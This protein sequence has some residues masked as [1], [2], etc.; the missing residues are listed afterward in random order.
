[1]LLAYVFSD[2]ITVLDLT[3]MKVNKTIKPVPM[4]QL[5]RLELCGLDELDVDTAEALLKAASNLQ[6]LTLDS[7]AE[8]GNIR[9]VNALKNLSK[10]HSLSLSAASWVTDG[11]LANMIPSLDKLESLNV[12]HTPVSD[13]GIRII[14]HRCPNLT[15]LNL[16]HSEVTNPLVDQLIK[17]IEDRKS[18]HE[19]LKEKSPMLV[20]TPFE[21]V[22]DSTL[23][24]EENL[25]KL[26]KSMDVCI[27]D[28]DE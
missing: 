18:K 9:V 26:Q 20:L 15:Y 10:L 17:Y 1:M 7:S 27:E 19:K 6:I 5:E 14:L 16:K 4:P 22:I 11:I 21:L 8:L 28:D 3:G 24:D 12:S 13:A 25:A 2:I 23:F